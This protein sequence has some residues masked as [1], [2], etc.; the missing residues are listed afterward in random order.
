M[1]KDYYLPDDLGQ[2]SD[3]LVALQQTC[4]QA[5]QVA[6]TADFGKKQEL[7]ITIDSHLRTLQTLHQ[8]K[9]IADLGLSYNDAAKAMML[10]FGCKK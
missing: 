5:L 4:I 6:T 10:V 2:V 1:I 8:K 7:L 3:E 9:L